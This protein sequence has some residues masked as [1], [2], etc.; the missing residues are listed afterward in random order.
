MGRRSVA[1]RYFPRA[2]TFATGGKERH[3]NGTSLWLSFR[4]TSPHLQFHQGFGPGLVFN[5]KESRRAGFESSLL[6]LAVT[7]WLPVP[8]ERSSGP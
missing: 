7:D 4:A 3:A 1:A 5:I 8:G 6:V 2:K